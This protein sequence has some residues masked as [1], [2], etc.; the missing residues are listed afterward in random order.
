MKLD[1]PPL[2]PRVLAV[3]AIPDAPD[4]LAKSLGL[5]AG[6][7]A[8]GVI[9]T[10][11]DDALYAALDQGTKAS[12]ADVVYAKSFYAGAGY[13]SGPF[14]GECIGIYAG[15][16]PAEI[17]AALD[18]CIA[19]LD[20]E[21][22]FYGI[23]VAADPAR[24][25]ALFPHVIAS[26]GRY[27]APLADIEI[28]SPLAYLIA[29]PLESIVG[30]DA[31]CKAGRVRMVKW[32]GP[33]SET[34]FGGAYLAGDLPSCEAAAR[35]FATAIADVCAAPLA[36]RSARGAGETPSVAARAAAAMGPEAGRF[37]ALDTGERFTAKPDHLTHLMDDASLVPKTHP[38]IVARGKIDL[39]QSALLD[40][41]VAADAD[42]ARSLVGELGE[43]LE[44]ARALVG[45]EVTGK[46]VPPPT[47]FGMASDE[48][49]D[50]THHTHELYGVPFMYPDVRQGPVVAKLALARGI[51][52]EAELAVI[53]AFPPERGPVTSP[54]ARAD[55]AHALNRISSALYLLSVR[56]VAGLYQ[57]SRRPLGPVRGWRP[58]V[59]VEK[60]EKPGKQ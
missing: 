27:L 26:V 12:P 60:P 55:L 43:I 11:S 3:R 53:T 50:A 20:K 45:A 13:P 49:R 42:G 8:L 51:A 52:R 33:P 2:K 18:A 34:N 46:E 36:R 5:P 59:K 48:I 58:P 30:L 23:A 10:T 24:P 1:L 35:A 57:G 14:S 54:P 15:R 21:A 17:D 38:R 19:Y 22:W 47:L 44:L 25:V 9:T 6:R 16:D 31:A 41:Q 32:F 56:Y 39:L 40:A 4:D 29:P 28:G 37:R 7:R